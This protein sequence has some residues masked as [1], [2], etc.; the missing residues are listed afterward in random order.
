M[1]TQFPTANGVSLHKPLPPSVKFRRGCRHDVYAGPLACVLRAGLIVESQI[2]ECPV[3]KA[4]MA[5]LYRGERVRP[6]AV[7]IPH[8]QH[9]V[10]VRRIVSSRRD[11]LEVWVGLPPE[12]SEQRQAEERA[13]RDREWTQA[14]ERAYR[15]YLSNPEELRQDA[16]DLCTRLAWLIANHTEGDHTRKEPKYLSRFSPDG[17]DDVLDG[18]VDLQEWLV[19]NR[20]QKLAE[21]DSKLQTAR[22]DK[23]FQAF[24]REQCVCKG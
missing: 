14:R 23:T 7:N 2:P 21:P 9:Y 19:A 16:I 22:E 4:R 5:T 10:R 11:H 18:L 3:G 8:D 1:A 12:E 6:G 13:E 15:A 17:I 24:L 20:I